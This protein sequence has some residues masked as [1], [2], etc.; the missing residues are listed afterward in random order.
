MF[1][2]SSS[3]YKDIASYINSISDLK[4]RCVGGSAKCICKCIPKRWQLKNTFS[5]QDKAVSAASKRI[6]DF[7][8]PS[9]T[10][11]LDCHSLNVIYLITC[12]RFNHLQN[13][14][15]DSPC[16]SRIHL[17]AMQIRNLKQTSIL[18]N[19]SLNLFVHNAPFP[20][21]QKTSENRN[22]FR[23]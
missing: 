9:N 4:K 14:L 23:G 5:A 21:P 8:T 12:S 3:R 7:V 15:S 11:Y 10:I 16:F 1:F 19:E 20:Y 13:N 2:S 17:L 18:L 6:F 22:A